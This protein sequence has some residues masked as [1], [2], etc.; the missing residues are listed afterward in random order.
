M[1]HHRTHESQGKAAV[2][3]INPCQASQAP[4]S[5]PQLRQHSSPAPASI[6]SFRDQVE[7]SS[8]TPCGQLTLCSP[9]SSG[10]GGSGK[11]YSSL[12]LEPLHALPQLC[13]RQ[14]ACTTPSTSR[15]AHAPLRTSVLALLPTCHALVHNTPSLLE[16]SPSTLSKQL[17]S[18]PISSIS[19][20]PL[21]ASENLPPPDFAPHIH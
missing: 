5:C 21:F 6:A 10:P 1:P 3:A 4:K 17:A 11:T 19:L 2:I 20:T 12:C 16:A 18:Q 7:A 14:P 13:S 9:F 15:L 8:R